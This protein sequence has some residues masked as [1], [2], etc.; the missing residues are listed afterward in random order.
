MIEKKLGLFN[1]LFTKN[2]LKIKHNIKIYLKNKTK[3]QRTMFS[4]LV[5]ELF[6]TNMNFL[7]SVF[8]DKEPVGNNVTSDEMTDD[9]SWADELGM[10]W[11]TNNVRVVHVNDLNE[12][13]IDELSEV[14]SDE[15]P[16]FDDDDINFNNL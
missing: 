3:K 7:S 10:N 6:K 13:I 4:S 15:M 2:Y 1:L 16:G 12:V 9:C 5:S 11:G 14:T 8:G